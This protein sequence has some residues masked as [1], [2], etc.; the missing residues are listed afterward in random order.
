MLEIRMTLGG[1]LLLLAADGC[2]PPTTSTSATRSEK[3]G[4]QELPAGNRWA[5][6][7]DGK[8]ALRL[9]VISPAAR[10]NESILVAAEIRNNGAQRITVI[11]PFGDDYVARAKGIKIWDR[12]RQIRYTGPNLSYVVGSSGFTILKLKKLQCE[13][14][15]N[16]VIALGLHQHNVVVQFDA[17]VVQASRFHRYAD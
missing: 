7:D 12:Q 13:C 3:L 15:A 10:V 11:R 9:S 1:L 17:F 8:L 2:S 4:M 14:N 5:T 16:A 6:S